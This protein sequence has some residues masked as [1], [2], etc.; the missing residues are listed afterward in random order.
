MPQ[1]NKNAVPNEELITS[2]LAWQ[3]HALKNV[4]ITYID[5]LNTLIY[6]YLTVDASP[7]LAHQIRNCI[8]YTISPYGSGS[9]MYHLSCQ[10]KSTGS[11]A[12]CALAL[13]RA[14]ENADVLFPANNLLPCLFLVLDTHKQLAEIPSFAMIQYTLQDIEYKKLPLI[15]HEL[16]LFI[17]LSSGSLS[18]ISKIAKGVDASLGTH[19]DKTFHFLQNAN[20]I[21]AFSCEDYVTLYNGIET[22]RKALKTFLADKTNSDKHDIANRLYQ[23]IATPDNWDTLTCIAKNKL[24]TEQANALQ[25]AYSENRVSLSSRPNCLTRTLLKILDDILFIFRKILCIEATF[26]EH[27]RGA[28]L[29]RELEAII[30]S[31]L[32]NN[33]FTQFGKKPA[34]STATSSV[35]PVAYLNTQLLC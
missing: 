15:C 27:R 24:L 5:H 9:K 3:I 26:S 25:K 35:E 30:G 18:K 32:T 20:E 22:A 10:L 6:A 16:D 34:A 21:I 7:F 28:S 14:Q 11:E 1:P 8:T 33:P 17:K 19:H 13:A 23:T 12:D 4:L 2:T 29:A 31:K